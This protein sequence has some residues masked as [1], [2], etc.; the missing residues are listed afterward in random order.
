MV[1]KALLVRLEARPDTAEEVDSFL[2]DALPVVQGESGTV[3]W[4]AL[5][6]GSGEY[7]IFDAFPDKGGRWE[8]LTG[9]VAKG[10]GKK[11]LSLF[12]GIPHMNRIGVLAHKLP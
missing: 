2:R 5:R 9:A 8:H 12:G 10:L 11:A 4:F 6:F 1:S 3:A 7:G